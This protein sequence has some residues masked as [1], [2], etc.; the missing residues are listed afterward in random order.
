V[1][2]GIDLAVWDDDLPDSRL[3][4]RSLARNVRV[5]GGTPAYLERKGRPESI[6]EL[7]THNCLRAEVLHGGRAWLFQM[8]KGERLVPLK[9][10]LLV[11]NGD[12]YREAVLAGLGL[13]QGTSILFD[14]DVR[15]GRLEQVLTDYVAKKQTVWAVYP[16]AQGR[17]PKVRA[18]VQFLTEILPRDGTEDFLYVPASPSTARRLWRS[19]LRATC[20]GQPAGLDQLVI[21]QCDPGRTGPG[22]VL[23]RLRASTLNYHDYLVATGVIPTE[24]GWVPVSDG[25]GEVVEVGRPAS[26]AASEPSTEFSVDDAVLSTFFRRWQEG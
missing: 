3:V 22:E 20:V 16:Q 8:P 23:V 19:E 7:S 21:D 4:A 6:E 15:G 11:D 1:S 26:N 5:T 25:A 2:Q 10:N 18:F 12:N 24:P 14:F 9:G 13:G 17:N